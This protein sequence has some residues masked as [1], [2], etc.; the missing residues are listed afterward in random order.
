[1]FSEIKNR[2]AWSTFR[3]FVYQ[4]DLTI[5][6][7][8]NLKNNEI[9]E[10]EKGEDIDIITSDI[11]KQEISRALEQVK[12][13]ENNI[14]LN[15]EESLELILNFFLHRR[16]NPD[17]IIVFRFVTNAD[18]GTERPSLFPDG[19][20]AIVA[21]TELFNSKTID[22]NDK[23]YKKLKTHLS[24]KIQDKID[25]IDDAADSKRIAQ[26]D[27]WKLLFSSIQDDDYLI[28]FISSFE[29]SINNETDLQ[30]TKTIKNSLL[31]LGYVKDTKN[32]EVIY[33]RLFLHVFKLLSQNASKILDRESLKEQLSFPALDSKDNQLLVL[34][35]ELLSGLKQKVTELEEIVGIHSDHIA[36]L[37]QEVGVISNTD[38]VFDYNL[39]NLSVKPPTLIR[40]GTLRNEK[41]NAIVDLFKKH[42]WIHFRGLNATGKSQLAALVCQKYEQFIWLDLRA[43]I[44]DIGKTTLL[45]KAFLIS[46]SNCPERYDREA[47]IKDVIQSISVNT[48]IIFNDLP[49]IER[50]CELSEILSHLGNLSN[51]FNRKILTI[52]NYNIPSSLKQNL[53]DNIYSEYCDFSFTD[54]EIIE[55]LE[56]N[57]ADELIIKHAHLIAVSS[58][59]NPRL[60][61]AIVQHLKGNNWGKDSKNLFSVFFKNEFSRELLEDTQSAIQK[62]IKKPGSRELLYRLSL[63]RWSFG[64]NEISAVS[65]VPTPIPYPNEAFQDLI[66]IWI[67]TIEE[68]Y[69]VSP[70]VYEIGELNLTRQVILDTHLSIA[71]TILTSKRV[72]QLNATRII[73]SF[74]KGDDFN[75][76]GMILLNL[77][78]SVTQKHEIEILN[79]W[80]YLHYWSE[81]DIPKKM[82]IVIRALIRKE[83]IRLNQTLN[84]DYTF[85][86][87][88]LEEYLLEESLSE[89]E[90]LIIRVIILTNPNSPTL[91]NFWSH[92]DYVLASWDKVDSP[93]KEKFNSD[94]FSS[95]LWSPIQ[96]FRSGKDITQWLQRV[97]ALNTQ[98]ETELFNEEISQTVISIICRN[99]IDFEHQKDVKVWSEVISN[100]EILQNYFK[101]KDL[102]I[103]EISVLIEIISIEFTIRNNKP[104]SLTQTNIALDRVTSDEAKY[105]L[106]SNIGKLYFNA[107]NKEEGKSKI[108]SAIDINCSSQTSFIDTL[109][110]GA[111]SVSIEDSS[112]AVLY[113]EKAKALALERKDYPQFSYLQ[114]IGELAIA[115]W[116]DKNYN[117]SFETFEEFVN[118]MFAL[119]EKQFGQE[120]I[121]LFMWCGHSL[122]YISAEI[123]KDRVPE[124]TAD[125][126]EYVKPYQ[127]IFTLNNKDLTDYYKPE[128]DPITFAHL[129]FY[130]EGIDNVSKAYGWSLKAFDLARKNGN[131]RVFMLISSVCSQYSLIN[132]RIE[133][134][135]EANLLL[136]ALTT[137]IKGSASER[138]EIIGKI[139]FT[140]V[141][142]EKPSTMWDEAENSSV[143]F[144]IIPSLI[145]ILN[146]FLKGTK[147]RAEFA[148]KFH[149]MLKDYL[150]QASDKGLWEVIQELSFN[151]IWRKVT[152]QQLVEKANA[153]KDQDRKHLQIISIL[154]FVYLSNDYENKL[155]QL[156]NIVP[157]LTKNYK[158]TKS[159]IKY[160]LIPFVRLNCVNILRELFVGTKDE[161][162]QLELNINAINKNDK[163]AI[164]K[165]LQ[166]L[167]NEFEINI[168]DDRKLWLYEFKEI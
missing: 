125:G 3:G 51:E 36:S 137:H 17:S 108:T 91:P 135:F 77:Y 128:N 151:I 87:N 66:H 18:Y 63:I 147:N 89:S 21:W 117:K 76:A 131:Q 92:F 86:E 65:E 119:K 96:N 43:Y 140:D 120:W 74:I 155:V 143:L 67:A 168:L 23:I 45:V 49:R 112:T 5:L 160:I 103:L 121:R 9:L 48:L 2:D 95:L 56:N 8:L 156:L 59:R 84:N 154:G 124:F 22:S 158:I 82:N 139:K 167:V 33:P 41:V 75:N 152:E 72:D 27:N 58:E 100:L 149:K 15:S 31:E 54:D 34:I 98:F 46:I 93:I 10:L 28:D 38:T 62:Y 114:V 162:A 53:N 83:Q 132:F 78:Q 165:I 81:N 19:K 145:I 116:V 44:S 64:R 110:Y 111:S 24:H 159:L 32:V 13:R 113:C 161:L 79:D 30:L 70:L 40:N 60:V 134:A 105:L 85:F 47:W 69:Q 39:K 20:S 115:Y 26:G 14:T 127:G 35:K 97:D 138:M 37:I 52:S 12:Y 109:L 163:N 133:E 141:L 55:F 101:G 1:M 150:F 16:N 166:I 57:G 144:V 42:D 90:L 71:R 142:S 104:Q 136:S 130:S 7:W 50:D 61:N 148:E 88:K 94:I 4:V 153:F 146:L 126:E 80:G 122:G 102:E 11:E 123:A 29:W 68:S 73:T 129:A 106:Q 157:Y 25:S 164:Q 99:L 107:G 118:R 6:R